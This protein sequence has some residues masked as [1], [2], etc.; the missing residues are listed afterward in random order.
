MYKCKFTGLVPLQFPTFTRVSDLY[1]G[2]VSWKQ[3]VM[4][5]YSLDNPRSNDFECERLIHLGN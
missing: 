1:L 4:S 3:N 5:K 2:L